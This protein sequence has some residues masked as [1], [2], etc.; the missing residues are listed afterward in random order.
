MRRRATLAAL[1]VLAAFTISGP[2]AAAE[3]PEADPTPVELNRAAR[4]FITGNLL[5]VLLHEFGHMLIRDF[6][7]PL[8][9]LEE[10]SADTLAAMILI[11]VDRQHPNR[12]PRFSEFLGMAALGNILIWQTGLERSQEEI[13]YWAQ[14]EVS[15][16]RA[17]RMICLLYGSDTEEFGWIAR[18]TDMPDIRADWCEDEF[19]VAEAAANWVVAS[20]GRPAEQAGG[21]REPVIAVHYRPPR[22]AGQERGR[23]L[24][25]EGRLIE[26]TA[27]FI[28]ETFPIPDKAKV[29]A[30]SC[31]RPNAFWDADYR[32]LIFCYELL[33]A[34]ERLGT[35]PE[36][37]ALAA[38]FD[39]ARD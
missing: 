3:T 13:L 36:V 2:A 33:E 6:E 30:R 7:I 12:E 29:V 20:Y 21:T 24:L 4:D 34:F 35:G 8:L 38:H 22:E 25:G 1:T 9:G 27:E 23:A 18:A 19:K 39:A 16:R 26:T 32:E 28:E 14:H 10:N 5:F 11:L 15:V 17:T 31:G 37:Q